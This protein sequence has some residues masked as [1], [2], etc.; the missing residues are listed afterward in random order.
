MCE[1]EFGASY[2]IRRSR[3]I[4]TAAICRTVTSRNSR[5][6]INERTAGFEEVRALFRQDLKDLSAEVTAALP[7]AKDPKRAL[8][9]NAVKDNIA[10]ALDP[11]NPADC[12]NCGSR[13]WWPRRR[14]GEL[15]YSTPTPER[16]VAGRTTSLQG[17]EST[18]ENQD[19]SRG[20]PTNGR[21]R[22]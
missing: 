9:L 10:R 16:S 15:R 18:T 19:T 22:E 20:R 7:K 3:L 21:P 12:G 1:R 2:P 14:S 5:T 17:I 6:K 11:K 8:I 4:F 13:R